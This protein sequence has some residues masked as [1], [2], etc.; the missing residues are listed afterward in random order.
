MQ[1]WTIRWLLNI[2]AIVL[3]AAIVPQF[4]LTVWGAIVGSVFL[5]IINAVIRPLLILLTLPLNILTLGLFTFV[6][7]GL[8]LWITSITVKGFDI[9][10]FGWAILSALLLSILSFA[11]SFLV[12]DR[13]F[14][15]R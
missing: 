15:F 6:I 5:G 8:M 11:I 2:L 12:E 4:E 7:N 9:H 1:G 14:K 3:T 13:S 10:G